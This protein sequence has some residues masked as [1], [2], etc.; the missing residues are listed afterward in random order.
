[1]KFSFDW[2]SA[3]ARVVNI[4]TSPK[5]RYRYF[6]PTAHPGT[7]EIAPKSFMK[8]NRSIKRKMVN[9]RDAVPCRNSFSVYAVQKSVEIEIV[10]T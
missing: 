2:P 3:F 6:V 5:R 8:K 4:G 10:S 1:M 7:L 9:Y